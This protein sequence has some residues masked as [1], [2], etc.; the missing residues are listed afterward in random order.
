MLTP[1]GKK[2]LKQ[3][4]ADHEE[5]IAM[6]INDFGDLENIFV[7]IFGREPEDRDG[8][9]TSRYIVRQS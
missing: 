3:F 4:L 8:H 7:D 1:L 6:D 2:E 5:D 9:R